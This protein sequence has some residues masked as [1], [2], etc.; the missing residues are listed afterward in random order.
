MVK[1]SVDFV[2][3]ESF[4]EMCHYTVFEVQNAYRLPSITCM[5]MTYNVLGMDL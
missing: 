1:H 2:N 4:F 3:A 5:C